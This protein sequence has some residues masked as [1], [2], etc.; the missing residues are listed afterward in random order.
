MEI[1]NTLGESESD[2]ISNEVSAENNCWRRIKQIDGKDLKFNLYCFSCMKLLS[3]LHFL[4]TLLITHWL[5]ALSSLA[6]R[7][8][9]VQ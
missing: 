3:P 4:V 8:L 1:Y 5:A 7:H 2:E 6:L 9:I